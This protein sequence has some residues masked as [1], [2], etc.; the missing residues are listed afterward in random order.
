MERRMNNHVTKGRDLAGMLEWEISTGPLHPF[1]D[2]CGR[3]GRAVAFLMQT[4][5]GATVAEYGS[6]AEYLAA[7]R[8]GKQHFVGYFASLPGV[9][10]S[11]ARKG[12]RR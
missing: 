5:L 10:T 7:A 8:K 1:Y 11:S 12:R 2:G 6:R 4:W 9:E 3:V